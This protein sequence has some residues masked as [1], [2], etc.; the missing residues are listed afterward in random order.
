MKDE[1]LNSLGSIEKTYETE[2][3]DAVRNT[4]TPKET[5]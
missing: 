5:K 4:K 1:L 2:L 3:D